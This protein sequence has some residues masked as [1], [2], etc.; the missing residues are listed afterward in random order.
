MKIISRSLF[1]SRSVSS[2]YESRD[3]ILGDFEEVDVED[4]G[5]ENASAGSGDARSSDA[6]APAAT[7]EGETSTHP[8]T[9]EDEQS[10]ASQQPQRRS[11]RNVKRPE[12]YHYWWSVTK[13]FLFGKINAVN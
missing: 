1:F 3:E 8:E 12:R 6:E 5:D 2:A 10:E 7:D 11:K 9:E 13:Y 4:T